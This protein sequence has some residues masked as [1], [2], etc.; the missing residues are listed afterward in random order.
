MTIESPSIVPDQEPVKRGPGRP[1]KHQPAHA[2]AHEPAHT[3]AHGHVQVRGENGEILQRTRTQIGD[4]FNFDRSII[5]DGYD[6]QWNTVSV[7]GSTDAVRNINHTMYANGWRPV[8]SERHPGVFNKPGTTGEI[9]IEGMRLEYRPIQLTDEAKYEEQMK[10]Y[11]QM[12]E[13]DEALMGQKANIK[14]SMAPGFELRN[15]ARANQGRQTRL[16]MDT[17][18]DGFAPK[19]KYQPA[20]D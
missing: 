9:V 2:P 3:S 20:E 16:S 17:S 19:P 18:L 12:K 8:P 6:Y 5:P 13:R 11:T 4:Q 14:G 10:A 15:D 1:P 7:A